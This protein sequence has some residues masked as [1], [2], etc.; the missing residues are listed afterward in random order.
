MSLKK[1]NK[2]VIMSQEAKN[3][4]QKG[5]KDKEKSLSKYCKNKEI[6]K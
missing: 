2:K 1:C 5:V 6:Y 4:L 3:K